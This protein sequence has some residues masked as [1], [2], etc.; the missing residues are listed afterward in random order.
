MS[1]LDW[2]DLSVLIG[3][4]RAGSLRLAAER[5]RL[6]AA[7]ASRRLSRLEEHL[8]EVLVERAEDGCS[9]T[10]F[11][12]E[13]VAWA[14]AME[15][16]AS[17]IERL[18]ESQNSA[19]LTG[20]VRINADPWTTAFL[21]RHL[22]PLLSR[23]PNLEI[24]LLA[25]HRPLSLA[26]READLAIRKR[27]PSD[28]QLRVRRVGSMAWGLYGAP[29]YLGQHAGPIAAGAWEELDL[30]ALEE[31]P[32]GSMLQ[33]WLDHGRQG[34]AAD[35]ERALPFRTRLRCDT[36]AGLLAAV[37]SG[38]GLALLPHGLVDGTT[39]LGCVRP[40]VPELE[41]ELWLAVHEA[42]T[43]SAR[44]KAVQD[45]LADLFRREGQALRGT[46]LGRPAAS[47]G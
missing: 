47:P 45:H 10:P 9:L 27:L 29:G 1:R 36:V 28:G 24:E 41:E 39:G 2:D 14:Q 32:Q 44:L 25:S 4:A 6:S 19:N 7:T 11:G 23:F 46:E 15:Q 13:V 21:A 20:V 5:L 8:G 30:L 16:A 22:G 26:R 40:R 43:G 42:L 17:A 18:R 31:G 35:S 3:V 37:T 12:S 34:E 38:A 33:R